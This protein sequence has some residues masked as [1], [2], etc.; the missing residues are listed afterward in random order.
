VADEETEEIVDD[1]SPYHSLT[2]LMYF[3]LASS[4]LIY[5]NACYQQQSGRSTVLLLSTVIL[6]HSPES[7]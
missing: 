5:D 7:A 3:G 4:S 2:G 1:K 6:E